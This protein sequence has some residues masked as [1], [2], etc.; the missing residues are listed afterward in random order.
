MGRRTTVFMLLKASAHW[1]ALEPEAREAALD[2]A[3]VRVF[4]GFPGVSFRFYETAALSSRYA[5][6][7][8]WTAASPGD[9]QDAAQSLRSCDFFGRPL[10]EPAEVIIGAEEGWGREA[11]EPDW[12]EAA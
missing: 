4:N 3:L 9:Y 5:A 1:Q 7:M 12:L 2:D 8:L 11:P 6:V 10:F